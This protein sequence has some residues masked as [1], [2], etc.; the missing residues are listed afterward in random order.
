MKNNVSL[1]N[2]F[3]LLGGCMSNATLISFDLYQQSKADRGRGQKGNTDPNKMQKICLIE[4]IH[5]ESSKE[6]NRCHRSLNLFHIWGME[7][8]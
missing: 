6:E 2:L 7:L 3:G 8:S 1:N 4:D 5:Q